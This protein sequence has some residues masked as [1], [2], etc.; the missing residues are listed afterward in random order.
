MK[1]LLITVVS[2]LSYD[3]YIICISMIFGH[4]KV[5]VL[6]LFAV[7]VCFL[8]CF[9]RSGSIASIDREQLRASSCF[10]PFPRLYPLLIFP[11]MMMSFLRSLYKS[12]N[13]G[14]KL[15]SPVL[16]NNAIIY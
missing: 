10:T 15:C 13:I 5:I 8:L 12:W 11:F 16:C 1:D 2:I 7:I 14:T 4:V 3:S 9:C 6:L